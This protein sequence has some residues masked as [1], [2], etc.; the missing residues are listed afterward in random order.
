[1]S[2][3]KLANFQAFDAPRFFKG[4][5]FLFTKLEEWKEGDDADHMVSVGTKVTGVIYQDDASYGHDLK[6]VNEGESLTFK[7]RQPLSAFA[8]WQAF[9]TRFLVEK[10]EKASIWGDYRNQLSVKVPSLQVVRDN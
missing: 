8:D 5:A 1:M 7:V 4:K 6:G 3:K 10:V 2:L 9:G